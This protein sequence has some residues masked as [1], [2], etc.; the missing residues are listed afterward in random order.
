VS[1][2]QGR[3]IPG[4]TKSDFVLIDRKTRQ[5]IEAFEEVSHSPVEA[6]IFPATLK[7]DVADNTSALSTRLVVLGLDDLHV[8]GKTQAIKNMARRVVEQIGPSA[9]LALVTTSGTFGVEPTEDRSML[10][11][12]LDRF[13]DKFDPEG[14]RVVNGARPDPLRNLP[15]DFMAGLQFQPSIPN[16][17]GSFF[18]NMQSFKTIEDVAKK[19]GTDDSRRRAMIWIS[20]GIPTPGVERCGGTVAGGDSHRCMA[21]ASVMDKLRRSNVVTYA[22]NTGDFQTPF[23]REMTEGSGGFTIDMENFDEDL[24]SLIN[25]LDH[26]YL[27]GFYPSNPEG[28]G[29]RELEVRVNTPGATVRAR[30]G[31]EPGAGPKPPKNKDPLAKLSAEVLPKTELS[32]RVSAAPIPGTRGKRRT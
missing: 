4:L 18:S 16:D 21:A 6:P 12:E 24:D 8:Q 7:M 3:P 26:Y 22:V 27:L 5:V 9:S 13:I 29:Y 11:R 17:T 32:L 30:R 1:D 14:R 19:I 2:A 31:Y 10:L 20:G 23:L 15:W 25:D 28:G